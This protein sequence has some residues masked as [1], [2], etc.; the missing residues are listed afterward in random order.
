MT[1]GSLTSLG[2]ALLVM[3]AA[4]AVSA[5]VTH[6][7]WDII[8][9]TFG[10]PHVVSAGGSASARANDNSIITLTDAGTFVAPAGGS[11]TSSAPTGGGTWT[12][13]DS[14]EA[15]CTSGTYEVT[16]LVRWEE[17]PGT[18]N[19]TIVDQIGEGESRAGLAVLRVKYSDGDRGV[20]VVSSHLIGTPRS[21]F[22]GITASK[23][24]V[25]YWNREAAATEV[26][27]NR[28]AF[29]VQDPR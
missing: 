23:G 18:L 19:P 28:T 20:L 12:V 14:S 2:M 25:D 11:G 21:V 29:H 10:M 8:N 9:I 17:A 7:R 27:A 16:G 13:C 4:P 1:R 15:A 26:N 3:A 6:V 24:I 5:Q 22:V